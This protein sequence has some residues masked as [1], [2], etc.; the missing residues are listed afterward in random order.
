MAPEPVDGHSLS[1]TRVDRLGAR[2]RT[3]YEREPADLVDT[4]DE[5]RRIRR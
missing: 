5:L 4:D 1:N 2:L 3:W